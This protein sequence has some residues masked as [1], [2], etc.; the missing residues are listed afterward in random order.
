MAA[1]R[2]TIPC[3]DVVN[4]SGGSRYA[5]GGRKAARRR[6][7]KK[8][9]KKDREERKSRNSRAAGAGRCL[10]RYR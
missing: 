7:G 6:I 3:R 10:A 9:G 2:D 5:C 4:D 1:T 8:P